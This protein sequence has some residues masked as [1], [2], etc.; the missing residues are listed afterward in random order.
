M[1]R[2]GT[3]DLPLHPGKVPHWLAHRMAA[4][5]KAITIAILEEYGREEFLRRLSD[6]FWFQAFGSVLGMDWHSSGITTSVMGALRKSLNPLSSELGIYICGGRGKHSRK[7][8]EQLI[9]ISQ[10]E[11]L[12][13]TELVR[14]SKLSAKVD[15]S[16]INDGFQLYLHSFVLS[17]D[18]TWAVV[19]Q[20]MNNR[21]GMA[22]RYHWHSPSFSSFVSNPHSG[23]SGKNLGNIMNLSDQRAQKAQYAIVDFLK[24]PVTSQLKELRHLSM[25]RPHQITAK[26]VNSKRLGAT[27][28]L[29]HE[30]KFKQFT[31]TLLTPG[32]GP[33]TVQSLA[34]VSEVIY[35]E[36]IRFDDPARFAFAHGGKDGAPFPVPTKTYDETIAFLNKSLQKAKSDTSEKLQGFKKLHQLQKLVEK[37]CHYNADIEKVISQEWKNSHKYGGR[38][39][40]GFVSKP[41]SKEPEQLSFL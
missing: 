18:G 23:I 41:I 4:L 3:A 7:T 6:P 19:Q 8:P 2:S 20:G 11:G 13:S 16:C 31:D 30:G 25:A 39:I 15:N 1:K 38:T 26:E 37:Q 17:V 12:N 21:N 28:A 33:R 10:K 29:A 22:R 34:L 36:A 5:G 14:A 40:H 24:A 35:G 27:L 32:I 9:E